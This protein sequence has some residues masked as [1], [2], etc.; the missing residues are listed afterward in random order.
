MA[1]Q[2]LTKERLLIAWPTD[3]KDVDFWQPAD[4]GLTYTMAH[5]ILRELNDR[6]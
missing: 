2:L 3:T 5:E 1:E 4:L 6:A